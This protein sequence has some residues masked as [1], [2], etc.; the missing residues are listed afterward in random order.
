MTVKTYPDAVVS[1]LKL[2]IVKADNGNSSSKIFSAVDAFHSAL[3]DLVDF[4]TMVIYYYTADYLTISALTAFNK[5]QDELQQAMAPM[6]A[7]F[8]DL[9]LAFS[10]NY[11]ENPTYFDH[12]QYF[13][14]P[15]PNGWIPVGTD[16][17]GGRLISRPQLS[18]FSAA[19][20]A[21]ADEGALFIGVGVS[22]APFG[23][24]GANSVLPAWRD[25]VVSASLQVPFN[26]TAP[27]SDALAAQDLITDV[28][29]PIIERATPGMGAYINEAD[30]RQPDWKEAFYGENY[31]RLLAV[32]QKWDPK[33][34]FFCPLAVGSDAWTVANDGRMCKA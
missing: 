10:L 19:A 4:G 32:K 17:F 20:R 30:F 34:V 16:Q 5:T 33:G 1:G 26:F 28:L 14:G 13:W 12:Y 24:D 2:S 22:V 8:D 29:Q 9:G 25:A 23:G 6:V 3:P 7:K 21:M 11:T 27:W 15:L 18:N 31:D